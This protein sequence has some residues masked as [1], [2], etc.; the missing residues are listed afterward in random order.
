MGARVKAALTVAFKDW[1]LAG[2][3]RDVLTS[4]VFFAG[5]LMLI[6]GF[7]LGPERLSFAAPGVLWSALALSA[8]IAAGRAFAAEQEAGALEALTLY[9]APH[10]AL[11][12]GKLLGT[13]A[14]LLLLALI[15]VP[16]AV[17]VLGLVPAPGAAPAVWLWL[18]LTVLLGLV[19]FGATSCFYAAIT[20]NLRAREAL[21]PVLAFPVMVPVVLASV[22]ATE[23][24]LGNG[25]ESEWGAWLQ[26]LA[27]YDLA[28][29]V[30][31]TLLFPYAIEG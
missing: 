24:L 27:L 31:S 19:G 12:L 9:P 28:S 5:L 17:L 11:Y 16:L 23:L 10:E 30:V 8:A 1:Q 26:F 6:L 21:L 2:R 18:T 25:L 22:R 13:L 15:I 3:T 20:V 14:Q 29:V 4:A 7:A